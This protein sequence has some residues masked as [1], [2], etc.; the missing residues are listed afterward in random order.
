MEPQNWWIAILFIFLAGY[1][2]TILI[3]DDDAPY[4]LMRKFRSFLIREAKTN[5][6]I[7]KSEVHKGIQCSH[8]AG[9]WVSIML[10]IYCYIHSSIPTWLMVLGDGV[11]IAS[12]ISGFTILL[13]R[14]FPP[15]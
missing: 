4:G 2:L 7:Q 5:K 1:R 3:T 15:K 6:A 9:M 14:A 10:S 13:I 11:I 12:A 8:C